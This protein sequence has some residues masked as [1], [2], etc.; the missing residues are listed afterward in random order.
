MSLEICEGCGNE[1][2]PDVC[3]C[4]DFIDHVWDGA[5][6]GVPMGCTCGFIEDDDEQS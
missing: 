6:Y 2:D 3:W 1:I 5:H 4:G